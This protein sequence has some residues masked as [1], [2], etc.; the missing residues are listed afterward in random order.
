M[1]SYN[2]RNCT[3]VTIENKLNLKFLFL[4]IQTMP[5]SNYSSSDK[6]CPIVIIHSL[7]INTVPK[8]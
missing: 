3:L 7:T 5:G 1:S 8:F 4:I 6:Q 2:K